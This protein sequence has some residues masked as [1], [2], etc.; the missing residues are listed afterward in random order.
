MVA[1]WLIRFWK[2]C[3]SALFFAK[4]E[5]SSSKGLQAKNT[6]PAVFANNSQ[7]GIRAVSYSSE[8]TFEKK[9]TSYSERLDEQFSNLCVGK[10]KSAEH[11][12]FP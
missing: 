4:V 11:Y 9:V 6:A 1:C 3:S 5:N 12:F 2:G 8:K 7:L 10:E